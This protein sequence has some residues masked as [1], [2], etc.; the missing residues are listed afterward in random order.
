MAV[1]L[2]RAAGPPEFEAQPLPAGS[3][4]RGGLRVYLGTIPD[5]S[6]TDVVGV[7][8]SGVTPAGPAETAGLRRGDTIVEVD[9]QPIEN[10]YDFTFALEALRVGEE[11]QIVILRDGTRRTIA[12]VPRS[13]D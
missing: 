10:L 11:A 7:R 6:E 9:G 12:V 1:L 4:N 5:Y 2:S 3:P 13:R 8:L